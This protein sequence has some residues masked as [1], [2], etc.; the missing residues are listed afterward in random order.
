MISN[1]SVV[2]EWKEN[3]RLSQANPSLLWWHFVSHCRGNKQLPELL[4]VNGQE[5]E[6]P[7]VLTPTNPNTPRL[8]NPETFTNLEKSPLV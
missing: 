6:H 2:S 3:F 5:S 7:L 8:M 1:N 4:C